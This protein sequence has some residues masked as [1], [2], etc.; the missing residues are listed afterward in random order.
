MAAAGPT[1]VCSCFVGKVS[2]LIVCIIGTRAQLIKMAPLMREFESRAI[3][4]SLLF[5]GQHHVTM[6]TLLDDFEIRTA[7]R[8]VYAGKEVTG[9]V[10]MGVWFVRCLWQFRKQRMQL[11]PPVSNRQSG[12]VL[13]HGDTF[14]TLLGALVGKLS[15]YSVAH[16]E[17]GLRSFNVFHPFPE[18]L[19]RLAVFRLADTAYCPNQW[20][21]QNLAQY[22]LRKVDCNGN[23][24]LDAVRFAIVHPQTRPSVSDDEPYA[25]VSLH[26]FENIF[27][28]DRLTSIISMLEEAA[29]VCR[30]LFVLHPATKKKLD[31][32]GLTRRLEEN[33]RFTLLERMGYIQF[34]H[35]LIAARF[36]IT[37]G[38]SNQEELSY[39]QVP[40][41][42]M[43]RATERTEG[44]G[45]N[46]TIAN[47]DPKI[48]S[49]FLKGVA[50]APLSAPTG[51]N[52]LP[53]GTPSK[54][55]CDDVV[56]R[57]AE[58]S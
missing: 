20:A 42:L 31:A 2:T 50:V 34:L 28:R 6:Q 33:L 23:T 22:A 40:T 45:T 44:L 26:R 37:D 17:S 39:L 51:T 18:E 15:G 56:A 25:V 14:S 49:A 29:L 21:Q 3:P 55:I 47:Y 32:F 43:R 10:Q 13:V 30:L 35:Y 54:T 16:V 57:L 24:L 27:D 8:W 4:Y 36:V 7:A 5:T 46:V 19:T 41:L 53:S 12:V 9:I 58:G 38:G 1:I 48:V 11:L 52:M